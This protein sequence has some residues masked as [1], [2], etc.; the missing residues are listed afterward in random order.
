MYISVEQMTETVMDV[1][2]RETEMVE[3]E[4]NS[5][6]IPDKNVFRVCIEQD[7]G[8]DDQSVECSK[9]E[10]IDYADIDGT[11]YFYQNVWDSADLALP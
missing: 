5:Y 8:V 9:R 7:N 1:D 6:Q 2:N 3:D 4:V 10:L 11:V